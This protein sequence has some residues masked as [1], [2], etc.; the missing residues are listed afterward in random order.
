MIEYKISKAIKNHTCKNC[1]IVILQG[2]N[3]FIHLDKSNTLTLYNKYCL[4]C[5]LQ[6]FSDEPIQIQIKNSFNQR[7]D[8]KEPRNIQ[9]IYGH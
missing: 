4:S 6:Q 5:A 3:Y 7:K 1:K 8:F 9:L 2:E